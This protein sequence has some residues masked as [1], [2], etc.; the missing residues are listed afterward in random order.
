MAGQAE[1]EVQAGTVESA[2][3]EVGVRPFARAKSAREVMEVAA[4]MLVQEAL[5]AGAQ[6][7][8]HSRSIV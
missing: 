7:A 5:E 8:T 3:W 1:R 6:A 2:A 4:G